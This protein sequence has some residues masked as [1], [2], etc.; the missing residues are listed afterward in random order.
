MRDLGLIAIRGN[1]IVFLQSIWT[2]TGMYQFFVSCWYHGLFLKG[3]ISQGV[4]P[5][6]HPN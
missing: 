3:Q 1:R 5:T 6:T 2:G 4:K